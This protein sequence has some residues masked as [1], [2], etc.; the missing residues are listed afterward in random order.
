MIEDA[1]TAAVR[2]AVREEL[3]AHQGVARL[4]YSVGEAAE[5]LGVGE[6]TV[7]GLIRDGVLATVPHMGTRTLIPRASLEALVT[8]DASTTSGGRTTAPSG[9]ADGLT[10]IHGTDEPQ[11]AA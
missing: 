3:A 11:D 9:V 10:V 4:T 8:A 5:A 2:T 7:R 1:I 6:T